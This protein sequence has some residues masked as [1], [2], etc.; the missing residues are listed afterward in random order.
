MA[1]LSILFGLTL[2]AFL[3]NFRPTV[4]IINLLAAL[5]MAKRKLARLRRHAREMEQ[6]IHRSFTHGWR[7]FLASQ[8]V[9][10]ISAVSI[11]MR[12]WI[13]FYFT[14]DRILI[15]AEYLCGIYVVTNLIN[16]V[17]H[18]PGGLGIFEAGMVGLFK[19]AD[20]KM[21]GEPERA[22][23]AFS[24]MT[25]A[26]DLVLILVGIYLIIHFN[27]QAIA[28]RTVKGQE[29]IRVKDAELANGN[30]DRKT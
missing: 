30:T 29:R 7:T 4:R 12:P 15:G 10:L 25:R 20:I 9:T 5:G 11:L 14:R 18:T 21:A 26:A 8:A 19:L 28:R 23:A 24:I 22:A 13:F 17:P 2:Y 1:V 16:M 3:G 27:M 6:L